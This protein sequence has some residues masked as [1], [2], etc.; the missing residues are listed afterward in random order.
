MISGLSGHR[1]TQ[2]GRLETT[3]GTG[4]RKRVQVL[5]CQHAAFFS[6]SGKRVLMPE[7]KVTQIKRPL[8]SL[9]LT[10]FSPDE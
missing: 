2:T 3:E 6:F 8:F 4:E 9:H 7:Q 1:E 5:I 10:P